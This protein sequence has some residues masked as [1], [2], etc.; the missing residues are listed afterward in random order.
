MSSTSVGITIG[1]FNG[2][3]IDHNMLITFPVY[4]WISFANT[5][6]LGGSFGN[7]VVLGGPEIFR[8]PYS[9]SER[10]FRNN[11]L[12]PLDLLSIGGW[13]QLTA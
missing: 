10:S 1:D 12:L 8:L 2:V 6:V 3:K 4:A 5:M 9:L 11:E 7:T 13:N